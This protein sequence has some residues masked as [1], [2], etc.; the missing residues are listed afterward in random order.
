MRSSRAV[1]LAVF[2]I[3]LA[4]SAE[5]PLGAAGTTEVLTELRRIDSAAYHGGAD[6]TRAELTEL[7]R[8]KPGDPLPRVYL[9][10][11]AGTTDDA[12]N[13]FKAVATIF[14]ENPWPHWGMAR[15]YSAWKMRDPAKQ[16]LAQI[17]KR[18]PK[19]YPAL[20]VQ[21][22]LLR[23]TEDLAGAV[24][25]YRAA[26]AVADDAEAHAGLGLALAAQGA[27]EAAR[28]EL[29]RAVELW[30]E[31]PRALEALLALSLQAKD[32]GSAAVAAHLCELQPKNREA[33][34]QLAA[35][36]DE[37][38]DKAEAATEYERA[39]RL[40][41]PELA[42]VKR[43]TA[44]YRELG[45][46]DGEARALQTLVALDKLDADGPLRLA[47]LHQAKGELDVAEGNLL[48]A[49]Q[50]DPARTA[51]QVRL[52]R[53]AVEKKALHEALE[54]FRLAAAMTGP[55]AEAAKAEVKKL[56]EAF[57]LQ[58]P[59]SGTV[60]AIQWR[61]SSTLDKFCEERRR[62]APNLEGK[63][64]LRVRV[65]ASGAVEGV[66]V[67]EDTVADPLLLGHLYFSLKDAVY[68]KQKRDPEFEFELVGKKGK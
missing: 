21:G 1:A 20:V 32:P 56:E 39:L 49:L 31:Q 40:G 58:K 62:A 42:D 60:Q 25:Q 4:A 29:K 26:L 8:A 59:A 64:R 11:M 55:D 2:S 50:R 19:F 61:V 13:Q 16:E 54:H 65:A 52:A 57:R 22:D 5:R 9:A 24:Q 48:E 35:L 33:R 12:W 30:P 6:R 68:P 38:G 28:T 3:S 7:V 67:L 34:R 18:D 37:A 10:S 41:N 51:T 46:A 15:I 44:L 43:L 47:E 53:L 36:R 63:Y 14:P 66:D 23:A 45:D 17:L 27:A